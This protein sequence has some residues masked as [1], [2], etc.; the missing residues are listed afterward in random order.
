MRSG[1]ISLTARIL[2]SLSALAAS[3]LAG[4]GTPVLHTS[5]EST[6][7]YLRHLRLVAPF[8]LSVSEHPSPDRPFTHAPEAAFALAALTA[9]PFRSSLCLVASLVA[10][11]SIERRHQRKFLRC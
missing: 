4:S 7:L 11:D 9:T 1:H 2:F 8:V 5:Q 6:P 10:I 3:L